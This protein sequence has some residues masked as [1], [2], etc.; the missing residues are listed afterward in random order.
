MKIQ[1]R[2]VDWEYASVF[3]I[4]CKTETHS[5]TI[6]VQIED[7]GFTGRG[8]ALGVYYHGETAD[9][10]L[11]QLARIEKELAS[12]PSREELQRLLPAGGVRNALDCALWDIEAK[13]SGHRIWELVGLPSIRPLA[14]AYTL[15]V[16]TPE[17]MGRKAAAATR[18]PLLKI[19]LD[20]QG[21]IERVTAIR[22]A[23]PDAKL[24][25]DANQSWSERHLDEIPQRLAA[26]G[27]SLIEQPLPEGKDNVLAGF[28]SPIP[29]CA[30]ESCQT[31]ASLPQLIGK[32]EYINIKLDKTG[33]LTE[34]LHLARLAAQQGFKLMVGC[35][36]G[37]SLSMAPGF[38]IG[39]LCSVV[40][41]DTPLLLKSDLPNRIRYDDSQMHAPEAQLWG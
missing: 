27:V 31:S 24:I 38:V 14:T 6:V 10:L 2:R 26:L 35:M 23:R 19:K 15:S 29:I 18:Y 33:G 16:D 13:R 40:D 5:E 22:S 21:D 30:D 37:S 36:G 4:A 9:T 8:E 12:T 7:G 32:Y 34:A 20:G 3:R 39:Q 11:E 28:K 25:V 41:L 17:A 1:F